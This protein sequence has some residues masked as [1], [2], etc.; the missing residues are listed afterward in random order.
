MPNIY[1]ELFYSGL[2]KEDFKR[3]SKPV[4]EVNRKSL[5]F[6]SIV[7]GVFWI[8]G[9]IIYLLQDTYIQCRYVY[10]CAFIISMITLLLSTTLV[11]RYPRLLFPTLMLFN[12]SLYAAGIGMAICQPDIRTVLMIAIV[13]IV[14][15]GFI[16][17]TIVN[18]IL[19]IL[20]ILVLA[21]LGHFYLVDEVYSFSLM[22]V[23][24]FAIAGLVIGHIIN[25]SRYQRYV[26]ADSAEKL[27]VMQKNY[28][29]DLQKEVEI[30]TERILALHNQLILGIAMMIEGRDNSTG[31]HIRRT[32]KAIEIL[33]EE[34]RKDDDFG[35]S[36]E[37][38]NNLIKA[39][40]MHDLG[41]ITI[42]DAILC[43]PGKFTPEEYE[44]MKT[45]AAQGAKILHNI[46]AESEDVK[47]RELAENVA[48]YHHEH[49]DGTGY[50]CGLKGEEIPLEARIMAVVDV[51]D[52]LV[53]KRTY[54]ERYSFDKANEIIVSL[55]GSQFDPR[56]N[57]YY[58]KARAKLE[59]YYLSEMMD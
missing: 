35:L 46:L 28:N 13:I 10:I 33:I 23:T 36:D 22:N 48:H 27:V 56:L 44:I 9:L 53:S 39:A 58:Q 41:K 14:P 30:K 19:Q 24:I 7:S 45:H 1:N 32:S 6:F 40:P 5:M 52:A 55:M 11:K 42:S 51:Y 26:Y 59:S 57:K 47:F 20:S 21:I 50:P 37:F 18:N 38:C 2:S 54:K 8:A 3:V 29:D 31:G 4:A 17:R 25:K 34:I 49:F 15:S 12:A 43:K 16:Q